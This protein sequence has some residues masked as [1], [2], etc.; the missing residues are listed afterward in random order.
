MH[1][2]LKKLQVFKKPQ[3]AKDVEWVRQAKVGTKPS[4]TPSVALE[5]QGGNL[6]GLPLEE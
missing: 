5:P 2:S 1:V 3:A 6:D 4:P